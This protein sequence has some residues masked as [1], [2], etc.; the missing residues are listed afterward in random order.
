MP[1]RILRV[2]RVG[3][4]LSVLTARP[5]GAGRVMINLA[6]SLPAARPEWTI[7]ALVFDDCVDLVPNEGLKVVSV[8][9]V[10]STRWDAFGLRG[11]TRDLAL[12]G[13]VTHRESV[14]LGAPPTL[15][16]VAEPPHYRLHRGGRSLKWLTRDAMLA[17]TF[18]SSIRRAGW[19]AASSPTT[20]DWIKAHYRRASTVIPPGIDPLFLSTSS[21]PQERPY[22]LH[23]AT[24][25]PRDNTELAVQG[26]AR[27]GVV[28][29]GVELVIAG[30]PESY[31]GTVKGL[32]EHLHVSSSTRLERWVPDPSLRELYAGALAVVHPSRYEGFIGLQALE[33]M[34]QKTPVVVLDAPGVRGKAPGCYR[35]A[36]EDADE[37]G[38]AIGVITRDAQLRTRLG[39]EGRQFAESLDWSTIAERFALLLEDPPR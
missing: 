11:A 21:E 12:D 37:L 2:V 13:F 20:A 28:S 39:E 15:M 4:D 5:K 35:V 27:S 18:R 38:R 16:Y 30:I 26:Y 24:G 17:A 34:A 7:F 9:R 19:L 22:L 10:A 14:S 23:M 6:R 25:D 33:A 29:D 8:P 31:S 32:L 3:L 1:V 36:S